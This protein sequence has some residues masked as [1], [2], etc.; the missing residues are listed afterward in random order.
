M[1]GPP[2]PTS[3]RA[4]LAG[5]PKSQIPRASSNPE[6]SQS[7]L[8]LQAQKLRRLFSFCHATACTIASLAFAGGPR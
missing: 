6:N 2:S 1:H 4:P 7:E 5:R 3:E 8:N